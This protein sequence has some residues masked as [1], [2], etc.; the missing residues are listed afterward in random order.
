[1]ESASLNT[2]QLIAIYALPVILAI[3]LHEA[4]HAFAAKK[5]GDSTAYMLG[6]MTANPLKHIDPVGTILVPGVLLL[7]SK[8]MSGVPVFGWAKPVPVNMQNLNSPRKDMGYVAAAGPLANFVMAIGWALLSLVFQ[9]FSMDST[10]FVDMAFAGIGVNIALAVLNL[11]PFP[12]LDG[13]RILVALLPAKL[14]YPVAR[15]EPYGMV[16]LIALMA[17]GVLGNIIG[18]LVDFGVSLIVSIFGIAS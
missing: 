11:L 18:P 17:T 2:I 8:G 7:L 3:T 12:P 6:R 16:I 10:F 15:L 9:Q 5:W 4:A 14:A 13:G 1:M